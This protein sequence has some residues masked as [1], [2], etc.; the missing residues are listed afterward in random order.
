[1]V[2][3]KTQ[4]VNHRKAR[5]LPSLRQAAGRH[6]RAHQRQGYQSLF[7][8]RSCRPPAF[9]AQTLD[10]LEPHHVVNQIRKDYGRGVA[11][12]AQAPATRGS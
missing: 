8:V 2:L 4:M 9:E 12:T 5:G 11:R 10:L 6:P 1:M 3:V 7:G